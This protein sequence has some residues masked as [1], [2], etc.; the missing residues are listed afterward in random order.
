MIRVSFF[1]DL[2]GLLCE[3]KIKCGNSEARFPC[4]PALHGLAGS[5]AWSS[6]CNENLHCS[7]VRPSWS[8]LSDFWKTSG[9]LFPIFEN[10][11]NVHIILSL[12]EGAPNRL[13][14]V[15]KNT[16]E[17]SMAEFTSIP[18]I[19]T[20]FPEP[21]NLNDEARSP[22]ACCGRMG[23]ATGMQRMREAI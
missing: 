1:W 20:G 21:E 6:T 10:N 23:T 17:C 18:M 12:I 22:T 9:S 3:S 7:Q 4:L 14:C 5:E 11:P 15:T 2:N 13:E 19:T 8:V 16:Q